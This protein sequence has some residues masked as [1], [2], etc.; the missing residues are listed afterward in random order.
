MDARGSTNLSA[1]WLR[2]CEQVAER[3]TQEGVDRVLLLTDGLAN[4]GITDAAEL[5]NHAGELRARG[6][7]TTTFGVGNDFDEA[8][9]AVDGGR[10]RRALLLH[11]G[12]GPDPRPHRE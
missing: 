9:L 6:V 11:R 12:R 5:A 10:R 8:L 2:G 3:L 4:V 1:G 7:T